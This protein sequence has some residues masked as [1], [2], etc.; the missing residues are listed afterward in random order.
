M[1]NIASNPGI[2]FDLDSNRVLIGQKWLLGLQVKKVPRA[3]RATEAPA[4]L[5][6]PD[7]I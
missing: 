3:T 5:T 2:L 7:S 6:V 1:M 4:L